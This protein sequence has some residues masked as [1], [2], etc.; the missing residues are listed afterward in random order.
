LNWIVATP[1]WSAADAAAVKHKIIAAAKKV[2]RFLIDSE[3]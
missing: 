1:A 2:E 3:L